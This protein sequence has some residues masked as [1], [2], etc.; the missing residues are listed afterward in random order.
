MWCAGECVC[1]R[2]LN[3]VWF[4]CVLQLVQR[5]ICTRFRLPNEHY[6]GY[7]FDTAPANSI[8]FSSDFSFDS[9]VS[10][11][12][13]NPETPDH[14]ANNVEIMK[15]FQFFLCRIHIPHLRANVHAERAR[16]CVYSLFYGDNNFLHK[17]EPVKCSEWGCV[18]ICAIGSSKDASKCERLWRCRLFMYVCMM[19]WNDLG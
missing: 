1:T 13:G 18:C 12:V 6:T 2:A 4:L 5:F 8:I 11:L 3:S 7:T 17:W 19:F 15:L 16:M 10:C 14:I 9:T